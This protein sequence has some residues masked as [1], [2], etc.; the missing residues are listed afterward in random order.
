MKKTYLAT[1]RVREFIA[2]QPPGIQAEY[3]KLVERLEADGYLIEP[4]GKKLD[5]DLFEMRLRRGRQV[6]VVY[7]YHTGDRVIG[8]HAFAKSTQQTPLRE[9]AQARRIKRAIED[10]DY[11]DQEG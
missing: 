1:R 7:F 6:R 8:V 3:V 4:F 2:T 9:L 10:D 11:D 5:R